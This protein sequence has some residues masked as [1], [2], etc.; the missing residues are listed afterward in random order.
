MLFLKMEHEVYTEELDQSAAKLGLES[1]Q[2][3]P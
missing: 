2:Q 3:G 1:W